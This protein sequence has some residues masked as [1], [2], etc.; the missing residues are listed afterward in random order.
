M[1]EADYDAFTNML[2]A[3]GDMKRQPQSQ[4]AFGVWWKALEHYDFNAV[5]DAL[6]RHVQN[7]DNGQFMPTPADIIKLID[8]SSVDAALVA[9]AKVDRAVRTVG[10]GPDV[11][12][13]DV[14]I[15]RVLHD[16]GGWTKLGDKDEKEWPFVAKEF[17]TRYRGCRTRGELGE[18]P[19]I[20]SGTYNMHNVSIGGHAMQPVQLIG[21]ARKAAAV[22]RG[23][24]RQIG[25]DRTAAPALE[26]HQH[27]TT[28][29]L[30]LQY[31]KEQA[32]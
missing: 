7:P 3:I 23:T 31:F 2:S 26:H 16:M 29:S 17:A 6:I 24:I 9:W 20:L 15:H 25:S 32:R 27:R 5:D 18:Y 19:P 11:A 28:P 21:D 13:D 22:A 14:T 8:G 12:F 4:W 10:T 1:V 30:K